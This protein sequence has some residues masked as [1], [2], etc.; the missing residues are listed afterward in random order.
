[1]LVNITSN[2][3]A[4]SCERIAR[5]LGWIAFAKRPLRRVELRSAI[6]FSLNGSKDE[7]P[8]PLYIFDACA[9][10]VEHRRDSSLAFIHGSVKEL[11]GP[12]SQHGQPLVL[13]VSKL[14]SNS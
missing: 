5:V 7:E 2:F 4:R 11:V 3:D 8:M 13:T 9:P 12:R 10:I 1:M 6:S 14:P